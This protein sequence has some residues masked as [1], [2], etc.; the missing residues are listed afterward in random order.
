[1]LFDLAWQSVEF[2]DIDRWLDGNAAAAAVVADG[3]KVA[4]TPAKKATSA[5]ASAAAA[6][7]SSGGGWGLGSLAKGLFGQ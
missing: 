5:A 7:E 4:P 3:V 2:N 1:M 6:A